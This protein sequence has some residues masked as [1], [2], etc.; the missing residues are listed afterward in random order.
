MLIF[1]SGMLR[2]GSAFQF[3]L[4]CSLLEKTSICVRHGRWERENDKFTK[5]GVGGYEKFTKK[6]IENWANDKK[7]FHVI[8]SGSSPRRVLLC[9]KRFSKNIYINRD[10]WDIAV[11]AKY[12][13]GLKGTD[14]FSNA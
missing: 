4:V 9:Q 5:G 1:C 10:M 12:K 11:A 2:S 13:W 6:Q 14:S 8:K 7:T 3:N